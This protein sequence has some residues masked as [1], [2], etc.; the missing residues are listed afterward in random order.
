MKI[1]N[2][3]IIIT[4][5]CYIIRADRDR[6]W[7]DCSCGNHMEILGIT[8]YFTKDTMYGDWSCTVY[9]DNDE[10]LGQFCADSGQVSC[11]MLDEV[12]AYNP[13]IDLWIEGHPWC[14]TKISNFTGEVYTEYNA[15]EDCLSVVGK[16][17]INFHSLQTGL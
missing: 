10:V 13:N 11:F 16:G 7:R 17:S 12:R 2:K 4:D 6:D 5:P 3:D 1:E 8:N 14:V 9:K 15:D